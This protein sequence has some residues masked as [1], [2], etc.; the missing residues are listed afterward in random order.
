MMLEDFWEGEKP[1]PSMGRGNLAL[2]KL[3]YRRAVQL[4]SAVCT[5]SRWA[6]LGI[7]IRDDTTRTRYPDPRW[8][9]I[10]LPQTP[11]VSHVN[12]PETSPPNNGLAMNVRE[13]R[14]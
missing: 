10:R 11:L 3:R 13:I 6:R 8:M 9:R 4:Q 7:E 2:P 1:G 14:R 12:A 5:R